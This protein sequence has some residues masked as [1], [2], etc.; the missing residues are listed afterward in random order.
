V[1]KPL[2]LSEWAV[3]AGF[4]HEVKEIRK[5]EMRFKDVDG[6]KFKLE[7]EGDK[8]IG[9]IQDMFRARW[10]LGPWIRVIVKRQDGKPF[11]IDD[12]AEDLVLS[13]YGAKS[14]PRPAVQLRI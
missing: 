12:K 6:N 13:E 11:F 9:D 5:M 1:V 3:R 8:S 14:D 4:T 10:R 2:G 7:V